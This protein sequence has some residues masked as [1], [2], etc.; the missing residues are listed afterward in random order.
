MYGNLL[1]CA[2]LPYSI[3]REVIH[4][5]IEGYFQDLIIRFSK[6]EIPILNVI[7]VFCLFRRFLSFV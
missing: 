7:V 1:F 3:F 2:I 6:I 5:K 4:R